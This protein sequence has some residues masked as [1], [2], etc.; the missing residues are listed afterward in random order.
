MVEL[1]QNIKSRLIRL[2]DSF[3]GTGST[4]DIIKNMAVLASGT[5]FAKLI[6]FILTPIIT[7]IY[8]PEDFGL[9]AIFTSTLA[10][11][12]PLI[13]F[14][15]SVTIPLPSNTGLAVNI[16]VL[17][18]AITIFISGLFT[19]VLYLGGDLIFGVFSMPQLANLWWLLGIGVFFIGLYESLSSMAVREKM[20]ST[21]SR[22]KIHRAVFG[23]LTQIGFGLLGVKPLGLLIGNV[24]SQSAG[25]L[26]IFRKVKQI[27]INEINTVSLSRLKFLAKWY[28]AFPKFQIG[29]RFLLALSS[30]LPII[31]VAYIYDPDATGQLSLS[32]MVVAIPMSLVGEAIGKAYYSEIA[33]IGR[34]KTGQIKQIT[35]QL[36]K[37]M[38]FV[39]LIPF[40]V[41]L[42]F[43]PVL[44]EI[45]FG[46]N[47]I[48]AGWLTS[49]LSFSLI[50]QFISSPISNTLSVF[51]K[52]DY[53][54]KIQIFRIILVSICFL[55]GYSLGFSLLVTIL[56]YS[57]TLFCHRLVV[58]IAIRKII[59][60]EIV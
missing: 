31:F 30:K 54:L 11:M 41:L 14:R 60:N 26:T 3:I 18:I 6:A 29:S 22:T 53:Y 19:T 46:E 1:F 5:A 48:E 51:R 34:K 52:E 55:L 36:T 15:Y 58:L 7:R 37:K 27:I 9:L 35:D 57:L 47:W 20:F 24:V 33:E 28:I 25:F 32:L 12:A 16:L 56:M 45:V 4:A 40:L 2:K 39:S 13:T 42:V 50:S 17:T 10:L 8:T 59:S 49:A 44:F 23:S 43:S 38:F 21:L